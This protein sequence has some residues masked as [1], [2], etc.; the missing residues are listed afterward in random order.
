MVIVMN[1]L[2]DGIQ[3]M[4]KTLPLIEVM[5]SE[6]RLSCHAM[7]ICYA[8]NGPELSWIPGYSILLSQP[9]HFPWIMGRVGTWPITSYSELASLVKTGWIQ[10]CNTTLPLVQSS[11]DL[12]SCETVIQ[13]VVLSVDNKCS[14]SCTISDLS[15][16]DW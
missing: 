7:A 10:L 1:I 14:A 3:F 5:F 8:L 9:Y 16:C 6:S 2:H 11:C 12:W 15:M 13:S 4:F